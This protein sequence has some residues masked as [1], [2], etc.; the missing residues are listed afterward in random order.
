MPRRT[1][2]SWITDVSWGD[3]RMIGGAIGYVLDEILDAAAEVGA[4][5]VE[6][7][8]LNV[9]TMLIDQLRERHSAQARSCRDFLQLYP[10]AFTKFEF[11]DPFFELEP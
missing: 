9:R 1:L 3:I 2:P 7:V 5:L 11:R 6:H 8:R 10:S 4:Q